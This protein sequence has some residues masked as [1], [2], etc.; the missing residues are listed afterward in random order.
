M[1]A[2]YYASIGNRMSTGPYDK[3]V[4]LV[5]CPTYKHLLNSSSYRIINELYDNNDMFYRCEVK[6]Y[7]G[8]KI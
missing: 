6:V 3:F 4:K 2:Y 8:N 1:E 5:K 7:K